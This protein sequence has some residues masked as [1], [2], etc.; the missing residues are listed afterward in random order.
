[1]RELETGKITDINQRTFY[2]VAGIIVIAIFLLHLLGIIYK[3][4]RIPSSVA[5]L[6]ADSNSEAGA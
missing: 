2:S 5:A 1:M 6:W 4:K 3:A